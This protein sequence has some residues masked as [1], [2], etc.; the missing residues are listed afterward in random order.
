ML[1]DWDNLQTLNIT[2]FY[3]FVIF[4]RDPWPAN[5]TY[6]YVS[7]ESLPLGSPMRR[8]KC[9][10]WQSPYMVDAIKLT[11]NPSGGPYEDASNYFVDKNSIKFNCY[12]SY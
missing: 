12:R 7:E 8:I 6:R 1:W 5:K 2:S 9:R 10:S 4:E 3:D 11:G